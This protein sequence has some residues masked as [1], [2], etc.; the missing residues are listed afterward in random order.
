MAGSAPSSVKISNAE[1][2]A[3]FKSFQRVHQSL[4]DAIRKL[5]AQRQLTRL[6]T[7][8]LKVVPASQPDFSMRVTGREVGPLFLQEYLLW[9]SLPQSLTKLALDKCGL[10]PSHAAAI[11]AFLRSSPW[12]LQFNASDND[13]GEAAASIIQSAIGHPALESLQLEGCH[14]GDDSTPAIVTLIG[15]S[16][17]L[18]TLNIGP[19]RLSAMS[20]GMIERKLRENLYLTTVA[21]HPDL[22]SVTAFVTS[23]NGCVLERLDTAA[24]APFQRQFRSKIDSFKSVKGREMLVNRAIQRNKIV[25]TEVFGRIQAAEERAAVTEVR[26]SHD[27]TELYRSGHAEIVGRRPSMED[28]SVILKDCPVPGTILFALF[29]GHGGREAAEFAGQNLPQ[30]IA[31]RLGTTPNYE[32]AYMQAFLQVHLDMKSWCVWVGTTAV[33]AVIDGTTLTVANVGDSRAVLFRDGKAIRLS[34]DHKPDLP[35]ETQYVQAKGGFVKEGRVNGMLAVSRQ[36][37][38]GFLREVGNPTPHVYRIHLCDKDQLLIL[39]CDGVWDVISDQSACEFIAAEIDPLEAAK[40]LR[41]RAFEL[42]S[43]DNISVIVVFLAGAV[44]EE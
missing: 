39:A 5:K 25:G 29:D 34:V 17:T 2:R 10:R 26:E 27:K 30:A 19:A 11:S 38:D 35:E 24:R 6:V 15:T 40:K 32:D 43:L 22:A 7:D 41:D 3:F 9:V 20:L 36:L 28:V 42:E 1:A 31:S 18:R 33:V 8:H 37:G 4:P 14:V 44:S 13:F 16:R 23:R 12:L 21:V